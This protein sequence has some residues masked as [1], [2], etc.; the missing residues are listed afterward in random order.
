MNILLLANE[1]RYTCGVTNHLLN[2]TRGLSQAPDVKLFLITGG[3]N[4]ADRFQ[5]INIE[6]LTDKRFLHGKR[7]FYNYLKAVMFLKNYLKINKIDIIHSH[8]HYGANIAF[9][10]SKNTNVVTIQ[11]NHG[12]LQQLGRIKHFLADYYVCINEHIKEYLLSK[13]IAKEEQI[14]FI[15]CG[16]KV[17]DTPPEKG[18]PPL[19]VLAASRF[20]KYKGV[21]IFIQAVSRISDKIKSMAEFNIAGEGDLNDKFREMNVELNANINFLGRVTD[22][23]KQLQSNHILVN[24]SIS[25]TEG[26]PAI[27]SEAGANNN[28]LISSNFPGVHPVIQDN[29]NGFIFAQNSAD[30]LTS[31]L[32]YVIQN[33]EACRHIGLNLYHK[34][35]DEF[36]LDK[37]I[38]KH[39]KLYRECLLQ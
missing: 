28:I 17:P 2:L 38:E 19:Q 10:A 22:I 25:I 30:E 18:G 37:M 31:A 24:P 32:E 34:I 23:Y 13:G 33:Y 16:I 20:T 3:G 26:F 4:G 1:I 11:T 35:K 15:R 21:D 14:K 7:D 39:L 5:D 12:I 36:N 8:T 9:V 6:I 27:I 29:I